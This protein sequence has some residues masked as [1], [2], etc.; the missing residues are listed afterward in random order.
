VGILLETRNPAEVVTLTLN[1]PA[2]RNA[3]DTDLVRELTAR[4]EVLAQDP[5]LRL[6]LLRGAAGTF[7]SGA[8]LATMRAMA[9]A[10]PDE[11]LAEAQRLLSLIERLN[12][13]PVPTVAVIEGAAFG[14][15]LGLIAACDLALAA[16]G[17]RFALSEVR[18]G[19]IPALISP[20]IARAMGHRQLRRYMLTGE[21]FD[22]DQARQMGLVH[23]VAPTES[24]D[25]I[26]AQW[27]EELLKGG[28]RAQRAA[29]M[30][31]L[32]LRPTFPDEVRLA[33]E[34]IRLIAELRAGAEGREGLSAFLE[35]R[36]PAWRPTPP[37]S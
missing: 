30:L 16:A 36:R 29:K 27:V 24:L 12:R 23:L 11:N 28:P 13:F 31:L 32:R 26:L 8:D 7:C 18:L 20:Y 10:G 22:A 35:K 17:T 3:L 15:A 4:L 25:A 21:L 37:R 33:D 5:T 14:G 2:V 34:T 1:R 19:L 6:L 9:E